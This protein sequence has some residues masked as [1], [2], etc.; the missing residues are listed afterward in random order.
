[1][2][3]VV[4]GIVRRD[5]I[6]TR[7]PYG[8]VENFGD[9][10][11]WYR[12]AIACAGSVARRQG[13]MRPLAPLRFI[14]DVVLPARCPGCGLVT[15]E[16]HRFCATCWGRL[17]FI[18]PPWCASCNRPMP[19]DAGPDTRCGRCLADPPRHA[20]V[21]A[22]VAYGAIARSLAL[23]LKYGG[24]IAYAETAARHM[25]RLVPEN[26]DLFV[27]VPL[28]RRRLWWRGFN[29]AALIAQALT[30]LSGV[31]CD[32]D[33]VRRVRATPPLRGLG[34][35]QRRRVVARAFALAPGAAT[36]LAGKHVVLIDDIYTS[37]AT[38]D[39]CVAQLL[40]GGAAGV[41]ILCWARV[42]DSSDGD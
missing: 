38:T 23:R 3:E 19:F 33:L 22:A 2:D 17:R 7:A 13:R 29:Q 24:K 10:V 20:G 25:A 36:R 18:A 8:A 16:D 34:A 35:I 4:R 41:T 40:R 11:C 28:H 15:G 42:L 30:R 32:V 6:A 27:P 37:G 1:M 21:R 26:A 9:G 31:P 5:A 39:G 12:H 14:A